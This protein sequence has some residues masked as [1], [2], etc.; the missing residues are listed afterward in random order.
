MRI[1]PVIFDSRPAYATSAAPL[2]T[3]LGA[4]VGIEPLMAT[5]CRR[6]A[7]VTPNAPTVVAPPD[8]PDAYAAHIT[9]MAPAAIV[10]RPEDWADS[11]ASAET[12]DVLLLIDP[13]CFPIDDDAIATLVRHFSSSRQVAH[14]LVALEPSVTGIKEHVSIDRNGLVRR[15]HRR[16]EPATWPFLTGVAASLVPVSSNILSLH[17]FPASLVELRQCLVR[18]GVSSRD[19]PIQ[20]GAA[21]LGTEHG[22]LAAGEHAV[23]VIA[24]HATG[25][26]LIVGNGQRLAPDLRTA[27]A[28][29]IHPDVRI[30][31]GVTIV[32][33]ALIGPGV[34]IGAGA[35]VAHVVLGPGSQVP[36]CTVVRDRASFAALDVTAPVTPPSAW[37]RLERHSLDGH[38]SNRIKA[39]EEAPHRSY[40]PWKRTFDVV[41]AALLLA[42]LTPILAVIAFLVWATSGRPVFY[43]AEREGLGGRLFHCLKFRTMR[44]GSDTIQ[45]R[46]KSQ[47]KLDGPHFKLE[48]DPR[49]TPLGRL[50]R[51]TNL[52]ELPQLLNVCRGEMSLVGPR[53]SPFRENQICVPWREGR[54]SV[55][56]GVTGLWQ[57]CRQD[58]ASGDFHQW[59]EYDLLYVQHIGLALDLKILLAT[60]LTLGGKAPVPVHWMVPQLGGPPE[61]APARSRSAPAPTSAPAR[62]TGQSGLS[63]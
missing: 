46:L 6:I 63:R 19:L 26:P 35:V 25:E 12:S 1:W 59:I 3:L 37:A 34:H 51:A 14:H 11:L 50:L 9:A 48:D 8:V 22:L 7:A 55:R 53:P 10:A 13:R 49:L 57:I 5:L 47:D 40:L 23:T 41:V 16:Y 52:D 44:T 2:A 56:P 31:E 62:L 28:V 32:G 27:G 58:R 15:V 33:P 24:G 29:V 61:T 38:V 36:P 20:H 17:P 45:H 39:L 18:A 30:D 43:R 21:D 60:V 42:V 54:L 4:P